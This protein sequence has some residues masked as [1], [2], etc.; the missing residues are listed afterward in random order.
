VIVDRKSRPAKQGR[1]TGPV[2][3]TGHQMGFAVYA[4]SG[5]LVLALLGASGY[6]GWKSFEEGRMAAE[7]ELGARL[8]RQIDRERKVAEM[9]LQIETKR[10]LLDVET[11]RLSDLE[12]SLHAHLVP[13]PHPSATDHGR[14]LP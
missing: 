4:I 5:A 10:R 7:A 11:R 14:A 2:G 6:H 8:V 1:S 13:M 3:G 9:E 12:T